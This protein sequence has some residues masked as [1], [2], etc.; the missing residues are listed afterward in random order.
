MNKTWVG[1]YGMMLVATVATADTLTMTDGKTVKGLFAGFENRKFEF[2][3]E[4][5]TLLKEYPLKIRSLTTDSPVTV[6]AKLSGKS[7]DTIDFVGFEERQIQF[8]RNGQSIREPIIMLL[9]IQMLAVL[10]KDPEATLSDPLGARTTTVAAVTP[11][12]VRADPP[13][14]WDQTGKWR[15]VESPQTDVIS[16]GESVDIDSKLK[17]GMVNV[18]HFHLPSVVSSVRQG[19]YVESLAAK[20]YNRMVVL[21]LEL[22]GFNAPVCKDLKINSLPQFWIYDGNGKLVKKLTDRFTESDIDAALK[23]ARSGR[24]F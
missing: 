16:R 23:T 10:S 24:A 17:K 8:S 20:R 13:R 9:S 5:G 7:Y 1:V 4:E 3:T 19:T 15:E 12:P 18:V 2:K 11:T 14:K 6:S 22:P 21:K